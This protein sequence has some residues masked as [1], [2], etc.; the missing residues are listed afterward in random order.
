M[1][2]LCVFSLSHAANTIKADIVGTYTG[3]ATTFTN[4]V[5]DGFKLAAQKINASGGILGRKIK[6]TTRDE[7][8]KPDTGLA[9]AKELVLKEKMDL[10]VG[11]INSATVLAISDFAKKEKMPFSCKR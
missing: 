7:K 2:V 9:M 4:D 10:L 8:F 5:L 6:Y 1:S 11:T 3:P